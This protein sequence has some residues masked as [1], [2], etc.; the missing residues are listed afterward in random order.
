MPLAHLP[1]AMRQYSFLR[2]LTVLLLALWL[3]VSIAQSRPCPNTL[4]ALLI[5]DMHDDVAGVKRLRSLLERQGAMNQIDVILSPGDLTTAPCTRDGDVQRAYE[6]P[7]ERMLEE[8]EAFG[9][10]VY[11]VP[12]N[13]DPLSLFNRTAVPRKGAHGVHGRTVEL[14]PGLRLV[15]WGGSSAAFENGQPVWEGWPFSEQEATSGLAALLRQ[16]ARLS[17][18]SLLVLAHCGPSGVGTT[19]VTGVDPNDP[20]APGVREHVV[21]SG[22]PALRAALATASLQQRAMLVLHGHGKLVEV[23]PL[24]LSA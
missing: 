6:R 5:S 23:C 17:D 9:R 4:R 2:T 21:D 18:A 8:L 24:V 20:T 10:P 14:A 19:A 12:G 11:F 22:S 13:H 16:E 3:V 1:H 15:G 7:A